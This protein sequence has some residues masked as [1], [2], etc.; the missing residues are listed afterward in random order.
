MSVR[1]HP[2][3][4]ATSIGT[5]ALI[6]AALVKVGAAE[7]MPTPLIDISTP[8]NRGLPQT[9]RL[10]GLL[11]LIVPAVIYFLIGAIYAVL[12][13]RETEEDKGSILGSAIAAIT[14]NIISGIIGTIASLAFVPF[15]YTSKITGL[16]QDLIDKSISLVVVGGAIN[17]AIGICIGVIVATVLAILGN[18]VFS[19]FSR[20]HD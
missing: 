15:R 1:N 17:G 16:S 11:W 7:G 13:R 10:A 4:I 2:F 5:I 14:A 20:K 8:T 18:F 6:I 12:H 9:T 19:L 3:L